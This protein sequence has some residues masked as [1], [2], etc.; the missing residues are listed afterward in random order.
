MYDENF[1]RRIEEYYAKN[2]KQ[3]ESQ[4]DFLKTCCDYGL[5]MLENSSKLN[6]ENF[7][8][9]KNFV[10]NEMVSQEMLG[11]IYRIL[12]ALNN[13]EQIDENELDKIKGLPYKF[14]SMRKNMETGGD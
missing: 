10:I 2:K 9:S 1:E 6:V 8:R 11:D 4:N 7:I 12:E 13:N 5:T 14:Y 3:F